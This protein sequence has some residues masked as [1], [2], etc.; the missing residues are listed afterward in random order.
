MQPKKNAVDPE[1]MEFMERFTVF[2][3][4]QGFIQKRGKA[5]GSNESEETS[6]TQHEYAN[7]SPIIL[8]LHSI[9]QQFN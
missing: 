3:Q 7:K 1:E 8:N 5:T 2:L 9:N 6:Q 4:E